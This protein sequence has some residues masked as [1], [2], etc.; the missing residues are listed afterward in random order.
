MG[1]PTTEENHGG[2]EL[3]HHV[4][5]TKPF[6]MGKCEVTQGQTLKIMGA[7]PSAFKTSD[8]LPLESVSW[9]DC[10]AL[11]AALN[12]LASSTSFKLPTEA[13]W[14]YAARAGSKTAF[15]F[16]QWNT[17]MDEYAWTGANSEKKTHEVGKLKPNPWGLCD[18][19]G[20]VWEWCQD[21]YDANYYKASPPDD[22]K[23]PSKGTDH[24][25]R[26]GSWNDYRW[27]TRSAW[28]YGYPGASKGGNAMG[29]R[30]IYEIR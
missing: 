8:R 16:S 10:Q 26:G 1:S 11:V 22:P 27:A 9:T 24:V 14:E 7:N 20:N 28:R 19:Y 5:I 29:L 18:I 3:E 23:G 6:Y 17:K 30:I 13:Q 15:F 2:D 4:K 25:M 12:H 21:V